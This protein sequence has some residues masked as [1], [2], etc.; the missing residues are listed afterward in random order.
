MPDYLGRDDLR[1][2]GIAE[3]LIEKL[4]ANTPLRGH[5]N[6]PVIAAAELGDL[7]AMLDQEGDK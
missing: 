5:N 1:D 2:L 4:L 6:Q 7:L 3:D